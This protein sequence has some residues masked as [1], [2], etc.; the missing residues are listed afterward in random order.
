MTVLKISEVD[1]LA[2]LLACHSPWVG[3][4]LAAFVYLGT[5]L[6][7]LS[8]QKMKELYPNWEQS[9]FLLMH[10]VNYHMGLKEAK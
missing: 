3:I 1:V 5:M 7:K 8:L 4:V 6:V 2:Y 10:S 9:E